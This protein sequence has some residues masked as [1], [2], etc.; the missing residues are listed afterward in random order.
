MLIWS[1]ALVFAI[2]ALL[3]AKD[4]PTTHRLKY[5]PAPAD[6]PLKGFVPFHGD[7]GENAFPHSLEWASLPLAAVMSGADEFRFEA[8]FEPILDAIAGRGHQAALR[9]VLDSPAHPTGV[10]AFL[11]EGGL[12]MNAYEAHGGGL[13]PDYSDESLL[14]ALETFIAALGERY[15]GD[16][17]IGYLTLGLLGFWGEWHTY[18]HAE[19]FPGPEIQRRILTAYTEAFSKTPLLMRIPQPD[20]TEWPIGL[21]D[22]SFAYT[23]LGPVDW[24]FLPLIKA[25]GAEDLW[26]TQAIGGELRPEIQSVVRTAL[27]AHDSGYQDFAECVKQTH[28]SWLIN[29]D[30]FDRA[31]SLPTEENERALAAARSLGYELHVK[32][33]SFPAAPKVGDRFELVITIENRGVAPFYQNWPVE[34]AVGDHR[35]QTNWKL[36]QVFPNAES[37]SE[38]KT[39]ITLP[40]SIPAGE[41]PLRLRVIYPLPKGLPLR[42]ANAEQQPDGWLNLGELTL[43][44]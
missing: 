11:L 23:T 9:F 29:H 33:A 16:P 22:D 6:N 17:R 18:P 28:A 7:H 40:D 12:K 31:E 15:D 1:V 26:R 21:H 30:L 5:A 19:W 8:E 41:H 39:R 24:H 37:P 25:A 2:P 14:T 43:T 42:F 3:P 32:S 10:P 4:E 35:T 13:S 27:P 38:W 44:P 36:S 34:I 20:A